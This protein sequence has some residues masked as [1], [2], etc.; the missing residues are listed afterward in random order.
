MNKNK[1]KW[2]EG[3]RHAEGR[4]GKEKKEK[5]QIQKKQFDQSITNHKLR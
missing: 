3:F 5:V 4:R 2:R 1:T